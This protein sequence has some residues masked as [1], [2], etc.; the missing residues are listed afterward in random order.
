MY[1]VFPAVH[2]ENSTVE[3][4][5]A[6]SHP[7]QEVDA[8]TVSHQGSSQSLEVTLTQSAC[9]SAQTK[10]SSA[11]TIPQTIKEGDICAWQVQDNA[12]LVDW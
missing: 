1:A 7:E 12:S 3:V 9:L 6:V 8:G 11:T 4:Q 10:A 5:S 2:L